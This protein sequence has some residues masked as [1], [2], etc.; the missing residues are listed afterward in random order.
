[1]GLV[2][3]QVW[4]WWQTILEIE[5]S[6]TQWESSACTQGDL[7]F[8]FGFFLGVEIF[9]LFFGS[10]C[11]ESM[12]PSS[13]QGVLIMFPKTLLIVARVTKGN[14]IYEFFF[15]GEISLFF[16][17]EIGKFLEFFFLSANLIY[18]FFFWAKF[19][20]IFYMKKLKK[21]HWYLWFYFGGGKHI[22]AWMLGSVDCS[23]KIDDGPI[24]VA[25]SKNKKKEP[26]L[27]R[28]PWFCYL[29]SWHFL[30]LGPS[31]HK[32]RKPRNKQL[33]SID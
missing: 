8:F 29:P 16:D 19:H 2:A 23:R 1:M 27:H 26:H 25:P 11:V 13:F 10:Q 18:L 17:K 21:E 31:P 15:S 12:F 24:N 14:H 30:F 32:S 9:S 20:Q 7:V 5:I 4:K 3:Q 6:Y 28:P 22:Y 33:Q